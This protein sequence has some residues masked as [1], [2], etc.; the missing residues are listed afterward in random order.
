ML[1]YRVWKAAYPG[2][3]GVDHS[4]CVATLFLSKDRGSRRK[5]CAHWD[6]GRDFHPDPR[7]EKMLIAESCDTDVKPDRV[8][9][10]I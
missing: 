5:I 9:N 10:L 8:T 7:T 2:G 4:F 6:V 1:R 3:L